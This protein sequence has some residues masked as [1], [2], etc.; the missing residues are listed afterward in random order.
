MKYIRRN[1]LTYINEMDPV[2]ITN[3]GLAKVQLYKLYEPESPSNNLIDIVFCHGLQSC[4]NCAMR[5]SSLWRS[6]QTNNNELMRD[7]HLS[8]WNI[9]DKPTNLE[10]CWPRVWLGPDVRNATIWSVSSEVFTGVIFEDVIKTIHDML[11]QNGIGE[12]GR[13]TV[14]VCHSLS[15][16]FIKE[17][18]I[19][20][21]DQKSSLVQS[22]KGIV[23][24]ATSHS[25]AY[26]A[27][28]SNKNGLNSEVIK[29]IEN[30]MCNQ[31]LVNCRFEH[32]MK[33]LRIKPLCFSESLKCMDIGNSIVMASDAML[34]SLTDI[35]VYA[36]HYDICKPSSKAQ[37]SYSVLLEYVCRVHV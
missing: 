18:L 25:G 27:R 14:F 29:N 36:N 11:L 3:V 30:S 5:K 10:N 13:K 8:N 28:V 17:V 4:S 34:Y 37:I 15:G 24:Y 22:L 19:H 31:P 26:F 12:N 35:S 6:A 16:N 7:I 23:F 20:A 9:R 2:Q 21:Q 32:L 33:E 1:Y